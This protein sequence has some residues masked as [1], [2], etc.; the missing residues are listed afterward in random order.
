VND[1]AGHRAARCAAA[2]AALVACALPLLAQEQKVILLQHADSLEGRIIDGEQARELIGHVAIAHENVRVTCDRALQYLQQGKVILTG[3][4]IVR[5]D[6]MAMRA[7][8]AVY[9]RE[10]RRAE[11]FEDV[12]L[13][14]GHVRVRADYGEY[15]INTRRARFHSRVVV[16]D[17]T[18]VIAGD[19]LTYDRMTRRSVVTG[20]VT[21]QNAQDGVTLYGGRLDHDPVALFSVM[22]VRP[23]LVQIDTAGDG[24][25]DTLQVRARRLEAYRDSTRRL[26]ARDSVEMVRTDL[27]ARGA[28]ACFFTTGD[29]IALRRAPV[30]WYRETQLL[31][32]SIDIF[33]AK[34]K[35]RRLHVTGNAVA[36]SRSDSL[37]PGRYDQM[38]GDRIAMH[39]DQGGLRETD[40]DGRAISLY[41][42]YDDSLANGLNK[43]SGDRIQMHFAG[44]KATTITVYGGVEG[45]YV[46]ENMVGRREHEYDLP[47]TAWRDDRPMPARV[48]P[49][50]VVP[51]L[52]P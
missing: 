22:T 16:V 14:D 25:A 30:I 21:V 33:L 36:V 6:S 44:G 41:F 17:S 15:L 31:G 10:E 47:G 45:Q 40:V 32:D 34:R 20:N 49:F 1:L 9:Y 48:A 24:R 37:Y 27:A 13:D 12:H 19:T 8:R 28:Y 4:V 35:L 26:I 23:M 42:L 3:N 52:L 39:F 29:S 11:G 5:D 43:T 38:T 51:S 50:F 46:P 7:P 18:S 2:L